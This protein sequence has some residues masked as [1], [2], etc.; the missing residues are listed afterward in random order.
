MYALRARKFRKYYEKGTPITN[1]IDIVYQ[2]I[3]DTVGDIKRE[4]IIR[5]FEKNPNTE[6]LDISGV[7]SGAL[8]TLVSNG[9]IERTQHGYYTTKP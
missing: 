4:D 9:K 7:V 8:S 6:N 2:I 1:P 3:N 5:E